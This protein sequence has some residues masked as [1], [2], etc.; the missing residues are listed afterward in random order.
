MS[1]TKQ[2][3]QSETELLDCGCKSYLFAISRQSVLMALLSLL[4]QIPQ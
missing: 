1:D 3:R 4:I 2:S